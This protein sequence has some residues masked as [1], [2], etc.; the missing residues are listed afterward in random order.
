M[1][2]YLTPKFSLTKGKCIP[3]T[4]PN[5]LGKY[6]TWIDNYPPKYYI[7]M[8][9]NGQCTGMTREAAHKI[10]TVARLTDYDAF[11]IE[12]MLYTGIMRVKARLN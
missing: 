6:Y 7:P 9:S 12:D 8:Y 1:D 4:P 5:Y 3:E 10:Y 11:R 2:L